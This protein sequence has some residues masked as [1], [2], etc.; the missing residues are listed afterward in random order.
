M[1]LPGSPATKPRCAYSK[2][3]RSL[4][5]SVSSTHLLAALV[6]SL[7]G[8]TATV[9]AAACALT[10]RDGDRNDV[11]VKTDPA[12]SAPRRFRR[13]LLAAAARLSGELASEGVMLL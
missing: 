5:G 8:L 10:F 6:T 1:A 7:G 2:S 11:A 3:V 9:C 12:S 13:S 4:K